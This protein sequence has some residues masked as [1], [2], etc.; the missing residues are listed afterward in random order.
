MEQNEIMAPTHVPM[1][2]SPNSTL[3]TVLLT[4]LNIDFLAIVLYGY[5]CCRQLETA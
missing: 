3:N 2:D 5:R 1:S 4:E